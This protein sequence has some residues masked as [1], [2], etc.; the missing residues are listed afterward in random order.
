MH[1][2]VY[3]W[4]LLNVFILLFIS[5]FFRVELKTT[6]SLSN[7][8]ITNDDPS[9]FKLK[10]FSLI[11][12]IVPLSLCIEY[13]S[14]S[15]LSKVVFTIPESVA[16]TDNW[17]PVTDFPVICLVTVNLEFDR[18]IDSTFKLLSGI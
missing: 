8:L 15:K 11:F 16:F 1:Q 17:L 10:L 13:L 14:W 5:F 2:M 12:W 7:P 9:P 4:L 3:D 6:A 18:S